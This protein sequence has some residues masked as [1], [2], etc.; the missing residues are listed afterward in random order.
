[1]NLGKTEFELGL[2]PSFFFVLVINL[3]LKYNLQARFHGRFLSFGDVKNALFYHNSYKSV[4]YL[5]CTLGFTHPSLLFYSLA[6]LLLI[7]IT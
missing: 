7:T 2:Y 4:K 5:H 1:M 3:L 6:I